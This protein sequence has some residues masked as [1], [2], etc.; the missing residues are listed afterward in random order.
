MHKAIDVVRVIEVLVLAGRST[1]NRLIVG[2]ILLTLCM[3]GGAR[4]QIAEDAFGVWLN[5]E[6]QSLVEFYRCGDGLCAKIVKTVDGQDVDHMNPN[7]AKRNQP[8]IG[9]VVMGNAKKDGTKNWSGSLYNR[10]DG[11][12]YS[13]TITVKSRN[14]VDLS[15]CVAAVICKTTTFTRLLASS[16]EAPRARPYVSFPPW[17]GERPAMPARYVS[18]EFT[19][20]EVFRAVA[21]SVYL[22]VAG[23]SIDALSKGVGVLGTVVA[24]SEHHALTNCHVI[25]NQPFIALIDE[26]ANRAFN[27]TV[28]RAHQPSDRCFVKVD[29]TLMPIAGVRSVKGLAVGERVYTIGNPSGLTNSL[30]EGLISGLRTRHGILYVQTTAHISRGSSGGALVDARGTLVGITS[31]LLKDAQNLNFAIA[32]EDYWK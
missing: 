27:A 29:G 24:V 26:A 20:Q 19:A 5:P 32:A 7:P 3:L 31:F 17:A 13:G 30:G 4:A 1:T 25:E 15:G 2:S 21:P 11:K 10:Y 8:I 18:K 28:T 6:N 16:A 12:T 14:E 23:R 22:V 9:L